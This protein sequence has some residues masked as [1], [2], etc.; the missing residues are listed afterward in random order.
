MVSTEKCRKH[1]FQLV[2]E[3]M[4]KIEGGG[5]KNGNG[6]LSCSFTCVIALDV[7]SVSR[8][9]LTPSIGWVKRILSILDDNAL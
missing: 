1:Q 3:K 2:H 5:G 9:M 7:S 8:K 6:T 4:G